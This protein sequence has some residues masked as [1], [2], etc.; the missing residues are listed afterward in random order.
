[1]TSHAATALGVPSRT[2]R[3]F[4]PRLIWAI[5]MI[6]FLGG[7]PFFLFPS[8]VFP[9]FL[10]EPLPPGV[11]LTVAYDGFALLGVHA[12]SIGLFTLLALMLG[13][14]E[15]RRRFARAFLVFLGAW[16]GTVIWNELETPRV[17]GAGTFVL[18]GVASFCWLGNLLWAFRSLPEEAHA[19]GAGHVWTPPTWTWPAWLLVGLL[20][21]AAGLVFFLA[22]PWVLGFWVT[23][24]PEETAPLA[25]QQLR[26]AGAYLLG[27]GALAGRQAAIDREAIWRPTA[28][29]LAVWPLGGVTLALVRW[30]PSN[31]AWP[32][33]V[34]IA[35]FAVLGGVALAIWRSPAIPWAEDVSRPLYGWTWADLV[36][37]PAMGFQTLTTKRRSSHLVGVGV[38]GSLTVS[39]VEGRAPNGFFVP[40]T[41]LSV[42]ARFANL[43]ELDDAAL[44]VRGGSVSVG[45]DGRRF[46]MVMNTGSAAPV[47]NLV[48]FAGFVCS[49]FLPTFG[50][51]LIVSGNRLAREGGIVGLRRAPSS[52]ARLYY[53]SQIVRWWMEPL[54]AVHLV[55]YRLAPEDLGPE[56]GLPDAED[57]KH[58]WDRG[59]RPDAEGGPTYL[60]SELLERVKHGGARM[61]FQV[62]LLRAH[63]ERDEAC[64]D[65]SVDWPE[66]D[67][68]WLDIGTIELNETLSAADC[69]RLAF[70]PWNHPPEFGVPP[71]RSIFDV[72]SLGDSEVR[73]MALVQRLRGWMY[74]AFGLPKVGP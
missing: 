60:R 64:Y 19:I 59:R 9:L 57:V 2:R 72:R 8:I 68:P 15:A 20:A 33:Y 56:S 22:A 40:G 38:R 29:L 32:A 17:Y 21:M 46:D 73:V 66:D 11:D 52:Y 5:Q 7:G 65:A 12:T 62:Q 39:E 35:G 14:A 31:Y 43:T 18:L 67:H 71:S 50:S 48:Q 27:W 45:D 10:A 37:G 51:E 54:G 61:R 6:V 49:K 26:F 55:R 23:R 69:E 3:A 30:D 74:S 13:D 34:G 36:N 42:V 70:N 63:R 47:K 1:M 44:D 58:I 28:G 4:G 24:I 41:K 16:V 53:H 25:W